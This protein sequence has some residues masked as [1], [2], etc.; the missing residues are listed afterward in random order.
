[1]SAVKSSTATGLHVW[2]VRTNAMK[3]RTNAMKKILPL[4]IL[5]GVSSIVI[6]G[7]VLEN[8]YLKQESPE[9]RTQD[10]NISTIEE[11]ESY[12]CS[13]QTSVSSGL[14]YGCDLVCW[15]DGFGFLYNVDNL[16]SAEDYS[17]HF[18]LNELNNSCVIY[19]V[20][21]QKTAPTFISYKIGELRYGLPLS[22]NIYGIPYLIN[23]RLCDS[24]DL[25]PVWIDR[26]LLHQKTEREIEKSGVGVIRRYNSENQEIIMSSA[27]L[28]QK[29]G[30]FPVSINQET[31]D[32]EE[33]CL[34]ITPNTIIIVWGED[35]EMLVTANSFF[36]LL[37]AGYI[38]EYNEKESYYP[39]GFYIW[40]EDNRLIYLQE[41]YES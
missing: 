8:H 7:C 34:S 17:I 39:I 9:P 35:M 22:N 36:R 29:K 1:M 14:D 21:L 38:G 3:A 40:I 19:S 11:I 18:R 4:L 37:N 33:M 5:I 27:E 13:I 26:T 6:M 23:V 10:S 16:G 2:S 28:N 30:D 20:F 24:A 32:K 12:V 31:I 25:K 41:L 15:I